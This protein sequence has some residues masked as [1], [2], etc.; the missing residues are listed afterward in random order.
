MTMTYDEYL[1]E[2]R[3]R[4]HQQLANDDPA[5]VDGYI[6]DE[7]ATIKEH[8]NEFINGEVSKETAISNTVFCLRLNW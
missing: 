2:C 4:L 7:A 1:A 6:E 3:R 5:E 8:Y